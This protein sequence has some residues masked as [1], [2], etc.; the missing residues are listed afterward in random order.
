MDAIPLWPKHSLV[1]IF[2]LHVLNIYFNTV[3]SPELKSLKP[4]A[5]LVFDTKSLLVDLFLI[6]YV[7]TT[8]PIPTMIALSKMS[9]V[10][11]LSNIGIVGL[12]FACNLDYVGVCLCI[13]VVSA[14]DPYQISAKQ[15]SE[16]LKPGVLGRT[17]LRNYKA[18]ISYFPHPSNTHLFNSW[19]NPLITA[20]TLNP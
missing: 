9:V 7:R 17:G 11:Y 19:N 18:T 15:N 2:R 8:F 12:N 16:T 20:L 1:K 10:L 4:S 14:N 5:F 3:L 13:C 6:S